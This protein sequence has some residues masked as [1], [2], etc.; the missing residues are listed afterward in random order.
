MCLNYSLAQDRFKAAFKFPSSF[1]EILKLRIDL[2]NT[3]LL[4]QG[5]ARPKN[6]NHAHR[7]EPGRFS[8]PCRSI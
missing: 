8:L 6:R 4:F 1:Y 5:T 7:G 3:L 2:M